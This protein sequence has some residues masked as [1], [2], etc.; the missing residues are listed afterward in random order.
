MKVARYE[1]PGMGKNRAPSRRRLKS[2]CAVNYAGRISRL[3]RIRRP[4]GSGPS[5]YAI[6]PRK[7][8][9]LAA[10]VKSLRDKKPTQLLKSSDKLAL[11]GLIPCWTEIGKSEK[12]YHE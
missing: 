5:S 7:L 8:S 11:M 1:V 4:S 10:I 6:Q 12:S 9:G 2:G 3:P